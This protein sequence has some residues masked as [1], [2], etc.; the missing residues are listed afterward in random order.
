MEWAEPE[1]S[2]RAR[3]CPFTLPKHVKHPWGWNA[4]APPGVLSVTTL[5]L[6]ALSISTPAIGAALRLAAGTTVAVAKV[7][8]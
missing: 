3:S 2:H 6:L 4:D 8:K 7:A 1:V 5:D